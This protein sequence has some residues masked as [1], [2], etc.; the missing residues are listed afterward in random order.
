MKSFSDKV[1]HLISELNSELSKSDNK[2][3]HI[4]IY[5][6]ETNFRDEMSISVDFRPR[7]PE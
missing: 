1:K 3:T 7:D 5:W 6:V 4:T 2:P